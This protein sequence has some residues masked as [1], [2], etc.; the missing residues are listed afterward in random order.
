MK[1]VLFACA[2]AAMSAFA[3]A[4]TAAAD[5]TLADSP[6]LAISACGP[7]AIVVFA[8]EGV[9]NDADS[10]VAGNA[11][12]FDN[13][14]RRLIVVRTGPGQF[15]AITRYL[16][17]FTTNAGTSPGGTGTPPDGLTASFAGGYRTPTC[18][19]SVPAAS[20]LL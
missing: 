15:C 14:A 18:T 10:G 7:G 5:T 3:L 11:W 13:Y 17:N 19:R 8:L 2:A 20:A 6:Q 12:A 1:R 16:G 9:K 4:G